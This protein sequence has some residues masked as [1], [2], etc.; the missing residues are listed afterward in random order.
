LCF[1]WLDSTWRRFQPRILLE[2]LTSNAEKEGRFPTG[3]NSSVS[4]L[5][6][7]PVV[8]ASSEYQHPSFAVTT[9]CDNGEIVHDNL[10]KNNR[11]IMMV[12][13]IF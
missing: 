7:D 8:F 3:V 4:L 10:K 6:T 5:K 9:G 11:D 2:L 13:W 12:K 1:A